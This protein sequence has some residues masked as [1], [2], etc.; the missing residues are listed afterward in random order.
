MLV[1]HR[2]NWR[3]VSDEK[4]LPLLNRCAAAQQHIT[5]ICGVLLA[6]CIQAELTVDL[7][8]YVS[9]QENN[10]CRSLLSVRQWLRGANVIVD[11][12]RDQSGSSFGVHSDFELDLRSPLPINEYLSIYSATRDRGKCSACPSPLLCLAE[13]M[14]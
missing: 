1:D 13:Y 5:V 10:V 11:P 7:L 3:R 4:L 12:L 2:I 9:G 8:R 6:W 14:L